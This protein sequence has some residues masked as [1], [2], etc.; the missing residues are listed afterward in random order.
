MRTGCSLLL[1]IVLKFLARAIR[2]E[3][4]IKEIQTGKEEVK[5]SRFEDNMILYLKNRK[6]PSKKPLLNLINTLYVYKNKHTKV[7]SFPIINNEQKENRKT[8]PFTIAS[9]N[10]TK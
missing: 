5:S 9:K 4:E 6:D 10:K 3:K 2:Q 8:I 1:N 7:T